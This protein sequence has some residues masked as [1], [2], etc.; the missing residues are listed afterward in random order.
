MA[1]AFL[2][3]L[4]ALSVRSQN[5]Y[6]GGTVISMR[7]GP[8]DGCEVRAPSLQRYTRTVG[9]T[10]LV[11]LGAGVDSVRISARCVDYPE[12]DSVVELLE[13]DTTIIEIVVD[14]LALTP[15][16]A[17]G[18][19]IDAED[20]GVVQVLPLGD[21]LFFQTNSPDLTQEGVD[22]LIRIGRAMRDSITVGSLLA[23]LGHTDDRPFMG[24]DSIDR[25]WM[26]S[27]ERAAAA[28]QIM[29]DSVGIL[30]C[31]VVIMGFGPSRPLEAIDSVEDSPS[32]LV[33]KRAVNRR[34]EFRRLSGADVAG[35]AHAGC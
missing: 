16:T 2:V 10:F 13:Q 6:L 26:L 27:G 11:N 8:I 15:A 18:D 22:T 29:I 4:V 12:W 25:N 3:A 23:I 1:L 9:G 17:G 33:R 31:R 32:E 19:T 7:D 35:E 21:S 5:L 30:P 34:I 14:S 20:A 24:S 28:A